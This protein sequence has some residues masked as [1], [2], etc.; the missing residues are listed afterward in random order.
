MPVWRYAATWT[1][2]AAATAAWLGCDDS[3][4]GAKA[5]AGDTDT[6][7][8]TDTDTDSDTDTDTDS[9]SDSDSDTD[10]DTEQPTCPP[11]TLDQTLVP[12]VPAATQGGDDRTDWGLVEI[13]PGEPFLLRD[14]L[15]VGEATEEPLGEPSSL[16]F[17][18][19]ITDSQII[20]EESPA[21][22]INGDMLF[23]SAYRNQES[24]TTQLLDAA[25]R[26][27]NDLDACYPLDFAVLTGDM[28]DNIHRDEL[29]WFIGVME[30]GVVDPDSGDDEDPIAGEEND[31]HDPFL[32][33]GISGEIPWYVAIGNHDD[34]VLGNGP[35]VSWMLADPTGDDANVN[36]LLAFLNKAVTP[37]CLAAPWYDTESLLPARCYMP[38]KDWFTSADVIPDPDRY[39]I[40][41]SEW[42]EAFFGTDSTPDGHGYTADNLA[43]G[44][45]SFVVDGVV[46]GVPS[47]LIVQDLV[48]NS[49]QYGDFSGARRD[50]LLAQLDAAEA[51]NKIVIYATHH[52]ARSIDNP[53]QASDLIGVLNDYP[54]VVLHVGGHT[55]MNRITPRPAPDELPPEHGYWEIESGSTTMWP[56]QTRLIEIVDNRDGTGDIY[57]TMLDFRVPP[58]MPVVEG[59]RFYGLFDVQDGSGEAGQGDPDDRNVVLRVAWSPELADA[60]ALLEHRDVMTFEFEPS[61]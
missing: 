49:G 60:L 33:E 59:G 54:N 21:R 12:L 37:V 10:T 53:A 7:A 26:T 14:D 15:G 4:P 58:L 16:T 43:D 40:D 61:D 55:H 56:Q 32:A 23:E 31:P 27:G 34:L 46:P 17:F 20:D 18:W 42:L 11:T 5:D 19:Q 13:G 51:E 28:I 52:T 9:D 25:I 6:D 3:S 29:D 35:L 38:P 39:F 30:G 8:D 36:D 44:S 24:W 41:R 57:C 2:L 48:S 1:V 45:A 47:V 22:L 50:W